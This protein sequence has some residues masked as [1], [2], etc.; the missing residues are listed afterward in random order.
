MQQPV[1]ES[2]S[3]GC[4]AADGCED[5]KVSLVQG[6]AS[7]SQRPFPVLSGPASARPLPG[8][9]AFPADGSALENGYF[10]LAAYCCICCF[11]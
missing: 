1:S 7:G 9:G 10:S 3:P 6:P 11:P 5:A 2:S 8:S 4:R